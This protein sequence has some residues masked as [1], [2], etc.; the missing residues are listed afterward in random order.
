MKQ[1]INIPGTT[2]TTAAYRCLGQPRPTTSKHCLHRPEGC[3]AQLAE[4]RDHVSDSYSCRGRVMCTGGLGW[5]LPL[6]PDGAP[7]RLGVTWPFSARHREPQSPFNSSKIAASAGCRDHFG[8]ICRSQPLRPQ[9]SDACSSLAPP[10]SR[11]PQCLHLTRTTC[12]I[13]CL[14]N[15]AARK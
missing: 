13:S 14:S 6:K 5:R 3:G 4:V 11:L 10:A 8:R 15:T 2:S 12:W 9:R 1:T 7:G